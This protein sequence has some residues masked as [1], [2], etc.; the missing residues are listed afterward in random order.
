MSDEA[1]LARMLE[2]ISGGER[3]DKDDNVR[4][5]LA[6]AVA[7]LVGAFGTRA[8]LTETAA[9]CVAVMTGAGHPI[10]TE[11]CGASTISAE[12]VV[13]G[14]AHSHPL[15]S[16]SGCQAAEPSGRGRDALL[17]VDADK[18]LHSGY[19]YEE[20][21]GVCAAME[22]AGRCLIKFGDDDGG[23]VD[24]GGLAGGATTVITEEAS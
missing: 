5:A 16:L 15:I 22:A 12:A 3:S 9:N 7:V 10:L 8:L 14:R 13:C 6:E 4:E 2:P 21:P 11:A 17:A 23:D 18:K 19:E 24:G 20:H 1:V